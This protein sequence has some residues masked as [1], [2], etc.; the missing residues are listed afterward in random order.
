ML[1]RIILMRHGHAADDRN[2]DYSRPLSERG[3]A[4]ARQ[5]GV[6]LARAGYTPEHV[7]SS[8]APRARTTAELVALGGGYTGPIQSERSLYLADA[9]QYLVA[10]RG[11]PDSVRNVLLVAHNPG[12]TALARQLCRASADLAPAEYV[13]VS[14]DLEHWAE[15]DSVH[16]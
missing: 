1:R 8:S 2:D 6:A 13:S 4:A 10:L 16:D 12:L 5:A 9:A 14:L 15:L 11:L 3:S 7:L